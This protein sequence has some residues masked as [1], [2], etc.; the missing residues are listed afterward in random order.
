MF[1]PSSLT[2]WLLRVKTKWIQSLSVRQRSNEFMSI[3]FFPYDFG[4][5]VLLKLKISADFPFPFVL[6]G[7][8]FDNIILSSS[9]KRISEQKF[10][11]LELSIRFSDQVTTRITEDLYSLCDRNVFSRSMH[12]RNNEYGT[13]NHLEVFV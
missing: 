9:W 8:I 5:D 2:Y 10:I 6:I 7:K 11:T 4:V 1:I 13:T 12:K 3:F